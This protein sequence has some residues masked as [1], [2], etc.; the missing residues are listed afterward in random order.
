MTTEKEFN[1]IWDLVFYARR[2]SKQ[3]SAKWERKDIPKRLRLGFYDS[4]T[5]EFL[6]VN[7]FNYKFSIAK[8]PGDSDLYY[9]N[10]YVY[11]SHSDIINILKI[12]NNSNLDTEFNNYLDKISYLKIFW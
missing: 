4:T 7:I 6:N 3:I 8:L 5:N 1:N 12:M 9:Y 2:K 10:K 11:N